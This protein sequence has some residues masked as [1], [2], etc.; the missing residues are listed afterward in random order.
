[1]IWN[2][3]FR[4]HFLAIA[5]PI[6]YIVVWN[7]F[8]FFL[9]LMTPQSEERVRAEIKNHAEGSRGCIAAGYLT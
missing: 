6:I 1:M 4:G 3:T 2:L 5:L 8:R 7:I 9:L